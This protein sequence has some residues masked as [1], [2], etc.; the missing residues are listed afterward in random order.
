[1]KKLLDFLASGKI[2]YDEPSLFSGP[3]ESQILKRMTFLVGLVALCLPIILAIGA[4]WNTQDGT[5][6]RTSIS[7]FYYAPFLGP[8]FVG[9]LVFIGGFLIAYTGEHPVEDKWSSVA[10]IGACFVALFPTVGSGC[11]TSKVMVARIL[12]EYSQGSGAGVGPEIIALPGGD[13][14]E[15]FEKAPALHVIAAAIVFSY[16]A[17]YCLI[18]MKRVI[19]D[20][21]Q[22]ESVMIPS[23]RR[24]N[25]LYSLCGITILTCIAILGAESFSI[26]RIEHWDDFKL[27]FVFETIALWAFGIAWFA[28]ARVFRRLND[29]AI[30]KTPSE[31]PKLRTV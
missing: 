14:F 7:H 11:E 2:L 26:L 28:K 5:C 1:M 18:V 22:I 30:P 21:H 9:S 20:R 13:Y 23:K 6:F 31:S 17:I 3:D 24:R 16:L 29:P 27:T 25:I 12:V 19:P 4:G 8:V 10:G 15:L